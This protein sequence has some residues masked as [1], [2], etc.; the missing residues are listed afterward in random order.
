MLLTAV[1]TTSQFLVMPT[2]K[3]LR[4]LLR[5][6]DDGRFQKPLVACFFCGLCEQTDVLGVRH[7]R[8]QSPNNSCCQSIREKNSL[9]KTDYD[10]L[11]HSSH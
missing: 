11:F 4:G 2:L 1:G 6:P 10:I 8:M 9:S 3:Q 5:F 7:E